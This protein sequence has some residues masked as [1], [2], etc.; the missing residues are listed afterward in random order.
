MEFLNEEETSTTK[1]EE[2]YWAQI[3][4]EMRRSWI[5][6]KQKVKLKDF[7][8]KFSYA[9]KPKEESPVDREIRIKQSKNFW[10]TSLGLKTNKKGKKK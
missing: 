10:L 2:Y 9:K 8:I 1:R 6:D 5:K 3:A 4:A 7:L